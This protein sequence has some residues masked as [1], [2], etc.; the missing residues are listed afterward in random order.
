MGDLH[1]SPLDVSVKSL[2][3]LE[4]LEGV[5]EAVVLRCNAQLGELRR[6]QAALASAATGATTAPCFGEGSPHMV[7]YLPPLLA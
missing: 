4:R 3:N 5:L 6:V 7:R 1:L 2:C